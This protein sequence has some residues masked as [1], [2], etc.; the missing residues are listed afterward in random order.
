MI[1]P[2]LPYEPGCKLY[3]CCE[4][5]LKE[6]RDGKNIKTVDGKTGKKVTI[7]GTQIVFCDM[8]T[9][10]G[11][12]KS[13]ANDDVSTEADDSFDA[14]SARLYEDMRDYLAKKGIPREEI[15]FIHEADTDLKRKQLFADMNAGKV[16]VLIGST[17]K[18][19]VG[20][21]AQRC[22]TAIHH[23]DAPW[24]PGDVEQRDGRAFR[25]GNLNDEVA[26]YVYVTTGSFDAR[27]WDILDR[28]SGFIN[29]IMNGDDVG[30][31]AEDTGDVTLSAAE[32][33]ALASGNPMIKESV[34]LAD[35]LQKLNG[36][37]RTH[38]SAVIRARTNLQNDIKSIASLEMSIEARKADLKKRTDTYSEEKFSMQIGGKTFSDRKDAGEAL[39]SAILTNAKTE[40]EYAEIGSFAGFQRRKLQDWKRS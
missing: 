24:R 23:L 36:L 12:D 6:Y 26:K 31:N 18:M 30:R 19:G 14:E 17:G 8:A 3:R 29:Q 11:K 37:K 25:Q 27:L 22:V 7:N 16:R 1:D 5:I 10:K 34:E 40:N 39:L 4:N 20:M 2:T 35:E 15:A 28:K 21:N 9:P 33:K 13:K 32:V 38:D